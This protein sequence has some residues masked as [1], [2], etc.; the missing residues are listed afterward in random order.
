MQQNADAF[1]ND[2]L[3]QRPPFSMSPAERSAEGSL[4]DVEQSCDMFRRAAVKH[5]RVGPPSA[6]TSYPLAAAPNLRAGR[7]PAPRGV[8]FPFRVSVASLACNVLIY[9]HLLQHF[10][11]VAKLEHFQSPQIRQT[12]LFGITVNFSLT[13][14]R[15]RAVS[16]SERHPVAVEILQVSVDLPRGGAHPEINSNID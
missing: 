8:E 9:R 5:Q 13:S 12:N 7:V 2:S 4:R 14:K 11:S 15:L 16:K 10:Y 6:R 3:I 1:P